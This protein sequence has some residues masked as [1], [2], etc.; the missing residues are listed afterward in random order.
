[1]QTVMPL[2][3]QVKMKLEIA[4]VG[5]FGKWVPAFTNTVCHIGPGGLILTKNVLAIA[6]TSGM[7]L[8]KQLY[9]KSQN[10]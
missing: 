1:M 5:N 8:I 4:T 9:L 10:T 3:M 7:I 2:V 6:N